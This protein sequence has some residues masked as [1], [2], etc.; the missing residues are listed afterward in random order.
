MSA[1]RRQILALLKKLGVDVTDA[2]LADA[3]GITTRAQIAVLESALLSGD[4][5]VIM[6]S[7]GFRSGAWSGLTESMRNAYISSGTFTL[8][9]EVPKRFGMMFDWTNPRAEKWLSDNSSELIKLI[10]SKQRESIK[11][12]LDAG[13]KAGRNPRSVALDIVGRVSAQTGKRSGG[14]VGLSRPQTKYV[15]SMRTEL[16]TLDSNYFTRKLRDKRF[17]GIVKKAIESGTPL[18]ETDINR[19]VGRYSDRLLEKRGK[20]IARTE[21][22]KAMGASADEAMRQVIDDGLAPKDA[23]KKIWRHSHAADARPGHS[24]LDGEEIAF[25]DYFT[26]P[27]TGAKL[28]YPL[29]SSLGAGPDEIVNC[30]CLAEHKVDFAE[31]ELAR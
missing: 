23:V 18:S 26:N 13:M 17:D 22:L 5:D 4:M 7:I 11:T 28:M 8:A 21:T 30:R 12:F 25:D 20:D 3:L 6:R 27:V 16:E 10:D 2:Y 1:S 15:S 9:S 24:M 14:I 19:L 31:V 29:D